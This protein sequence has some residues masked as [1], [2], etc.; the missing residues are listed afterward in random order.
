[1][2][3]TPARPDIVIDARERLAA[4]CARRFEALAQD[5][6]AARG[7]F[8]C[9]LP[10][11]SVAEV[12]FPALAASA[13][14]WPR[15]HVF[16]G[17]ERAVPAEDSR[18]NYGYAW[19]TWL[20]HLAIPPAQ[21]HRMPADGPDLDRAAA[22]YD[23]DLQRT[24][25]TPPRLDLVLLGVGPDGHVCSLFPGHSA[26]D[27]RARHAT[28]VH[29]APK[30]PA[31]RLTLT[32]PALGAARA[33]IVGAFG[34][35]K[36]AVVRDAIETSDSPLPVALATRD[37]ERVTWLLDPDAARLLTD[38]TRDTATRRRR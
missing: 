7:R 5:A 12:C 20:R 26:L 23:A 22:A 27:E 9:A 33:L 10:G 30:P 25:G 8:A 36:A 13:V 16:W 28:A 4:E 18:S 2:A 32:L 34:R 38:V 31:R 24:L 6:I 17:D 35:E 14:D 1:M 3:F 19:R 37:D 29:D 15:A 21:I 11:G